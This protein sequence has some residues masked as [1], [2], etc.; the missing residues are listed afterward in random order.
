MIKKLIIVIA[1][2]SLLFSCGVKGPPV[3]DEND[4]VIPKSTDWWNI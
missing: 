3:H 4:M 2:S 1:L